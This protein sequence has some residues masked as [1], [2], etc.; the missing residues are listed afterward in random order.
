MVKKEIMIKPSENFRMQNQKQV[1]LNSMGS[2]A[3]KFWLAHQIIRFCSKYIYAQWDSLLG[4]HILDYTVSQYRRK[5][6]YITFGNSF[7]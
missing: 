3:L 6:Y 5:V 7:L 1:P 2:S 4:R